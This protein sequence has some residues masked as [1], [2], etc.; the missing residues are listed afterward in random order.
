VTELL[1]QTFFQHALVAGTLVAISCSFVGVYVLLKRIV[2]LGIALAQIASAGVAL[3]LL[4]GWDPLL[5]AL[6]ASLAGAVGF[7]QI[8]WRGRAPIEGVL[9]IS[10]VLAAALGTVFIAKNPVGE[11]RALSVLFGNILSVPRHE[12]VA[13]ALVTAAVTLVHLQF[14]KEFVFVSFDFETAAAHGV[15]A[16]LWNLLLY[17]TLGVAIAF[18]IRSSGV[19]VTFALL[20]VPSM[21]ARLLTASVGGMFA[22]AVG[23]AVC[24]IPVGLG[25]AFSLDLPTGATISLTV[26][27]LFGLAL[28]A[29]ALARS[30][31][32]PTAAGLAVLLVLALASPALAQKPAGVDAELEALR[33][34]VNDLKKIVTEQQRVI[35]E[36]QQSRSAAPAPPAPAAPG[37]AP[38]ALQLTSPE[39][40]PPTVPLERGSIERRGL[41]P[42]LAYLPEF[43]VE[44]NMIY[45][46]T[47]ADRRR[48]EMQLGDEEESFV[49]R[50]ALNVQEVQLGLRSAIDPFARFE[51]T[52]EAQQNRRGEFD[53]DI[54]EAFLSSRSLPGRLELK[55]GRFRTSFGEFN[56]SGPEEIPEITS[57]NVI[58]NLFGRDG[59]GWL[60]TGVLM[61]RIFGVTDDQAVT[62]SGAVFNGDNQLFLGGQSGVVRDPAWYARFQHFIEFGPLT[63]MEWGFGYAQGHTVD[64]LGGSDLSQRLF[65]SH[66]KFRYKEPVLALYKG[67]NFLAEFFYS[68]RDQRKIEAVTVVDEVTGED[69]TIER[70]RLD[71]LNRYGLYALAEAQVAR[72]WSVGGRFDYSQLPDRERVNGS[73]P[74]ETAGSL[75]I[76]FRPSRFLTLRTQYIHTARTFAVDSDEIYLQALFKLGFERPGPF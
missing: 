40:T 60:D 38:S 28:L 15:R 72:N 48:L 34:A 23:L 69:V 36:L 20:V 42:Y 74:S 64:D 57:P 61:D 35:Q 53:F 75:I 24:S 65:N 18:A 32:R 56:D 37:P 9:G 41:P 7:S 45:N 26:A 76:S 59:A 4:L 39:E 63:G 55:L 73:I 3:A 33:E 66:F 49:R 6:A 31:R 17:L 27:L 50:N 13:L 70:L 29:R 22:A 51:A 5:T 43:R 1:E 21:G 67:F 2:F 14:R 58:V 52:I 25:V 12:L 16:R 30:L 62:L 68:W 71:T 46:K 11:A 19:L 47:F 54:E 10:Y 8:R 44:G